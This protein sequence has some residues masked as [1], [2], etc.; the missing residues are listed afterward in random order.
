[1]QSRKPFCLLTKPQPYQRPSSGI[2]GGRGRRI[3]SIGSEG[4]RPALLSAGPVPERSNV[5][6]AFIETPD[7]QRLAGRACSD[8]YYFNEKSYLYQPIVLAELSKLSVVLAS[9]SLACPRAACKELFGRR[10][11]NR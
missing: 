6:S 3:A 11:I 4:T 10:Q 5:K 1:K 9:G 8:S 7:G 2:A